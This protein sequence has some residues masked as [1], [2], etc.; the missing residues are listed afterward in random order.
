[1]V[2]VGQVTQPDDWDEKLR[3]VVRKSNDYM[4]IGLGYRTSLTE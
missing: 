1:M 2:M 4:T 3:R